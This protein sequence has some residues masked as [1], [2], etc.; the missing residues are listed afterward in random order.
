M[1]RC[2]QSELWVGVEIDKISNTALSNFIGDIENFS[3]EDNREE[4]IEA[5]FD[6][7]ISLSDGGL[8][9]SLCYDGEEDDEKIIGFIIP[10]TTCELY[11]KPLDLVQIQ[12]YS[13]SKKEYLLKTFG[14]EPKIYLVPQ[15]L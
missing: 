11:V 5:A 3:K 8:D 12:S 4:L 9:Y 13:D 2:F 7:L 6:Y 1:G 10:K 15:Y 14:V